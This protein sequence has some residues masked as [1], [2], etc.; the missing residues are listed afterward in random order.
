MA[1]EKQTIK[2]R[3][4]N[5]FR[6]KSGGTAVEVVAGGMLSDISYDELQA[7]YPTS[8]TEAFEYKLSGVTQATITIT[9]VAT[10]KK[11]ILS[12]IRT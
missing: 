12:V 4:F 8:T 9:Y 1:I 7:T 10:N 6:S 11:D 5:K 2:D 3:E